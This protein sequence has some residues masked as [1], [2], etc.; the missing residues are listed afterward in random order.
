MSHKER[1]R[2]KRLEHA[3]VDL[4]EMLAKLTKPEVCYVNAWHVHDEFNQ[5][6]EVCE[7]IKQELIG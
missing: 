4:F 7:E 1:Q 6:K 5:L 2:I 3:F